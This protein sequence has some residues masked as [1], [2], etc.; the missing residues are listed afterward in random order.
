MSLINLGL[1]NDREDDYLE[2]PSTDLETNELYE[3]ALALDTG[4]RFQ[5][6]M[7]AKVDRGEELSD[8]E[9]FIATETIGRLYSSL[10]S[11]A[12]EGFGFEQYADKELT[13]M[14]KSKIALEAITNQN[15]TKI[16]TLS[17]NIENFFNELGLINVE[18]YKI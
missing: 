12:F 8:E 3:D 6:V 11:A 4:A 2:S 17:T 9:I 15:D 10:G 13:Q 5:R 1:E 16:K 18:D 14:E 7:Q